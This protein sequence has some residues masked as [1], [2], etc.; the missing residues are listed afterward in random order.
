MLHSLSVGCCMSTLM[1]MSATNLADQ[2][3]QISAKVIQVRRISV[4]I[5]QCGVNRYVII[6]CF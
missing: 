5:V 2:C 4:E 6:K 3:P 1:N